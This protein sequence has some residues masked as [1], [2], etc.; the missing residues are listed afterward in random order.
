MEKKL[1]RQA[2]SYLLMVI[3]FNILVSCNASD[4]NSSATIIQPA[5]TE[6]SNE[7]IDPL[8]PPEGYQVVV[9]ADTIFQNVFS[10]GKL[11]F[12]SLVL[13]GNRIYNHIYPEI[14]DSFLFEDKYYLKLSYPIPFSGT[15]KTALPDCPD[16]V[17]TP[18]GK[19]ILQ[20]V[21]YNA[22]DI[23]AIDFIFT[24]L[25]SENDSLILSEYFFEYVVFE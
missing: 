23:E 6:N 3:L 14:S 25:P 17:L 20:V 5:N 7:K 9:K 12:E 24:Y 4:K 10:D 21:V 16:Y 18:I 2:I 15:I 1:I 19:D 8:T 22:L 11:H 13:D